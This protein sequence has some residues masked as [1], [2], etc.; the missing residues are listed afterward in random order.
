MTGI[1]GLRSC[2]AVAACAIAT[3]SPGQTAPPA[4]AS[5]TQG[6]APGK[7][8]PST[9]S[10]VPPTQAPAT[11]APVAKPQDWNFHLQT[12]AIEQ[13]DLGFP[14]KYSGPNSLSSRGQGQHTETLDL[15]A[16]K[17][18]WRGAEFHV[19][20][21]I[22]QGFGLSET[23]GIEAFPNGDAYKFG[24][25]TPYFIFARLFIRQTFG[26][27]GP[28][29]DVPDTAL[30][31][32]GKQDIS[33]ITLTA[34]RFTP[35]DVVDTNAYASNPRTQFMNWGFVNNLTWDYPAD[36]VGYT[37]GLT[38]ELNQPKWA[39]RYGCFVMPPVANSF[40]GDD[41]FLM[42]PHEGSF[43]PI[44]KEWAMNL[45][46]ERRYT[47]K[48]HPGSIRP[49]A[50][51]NQAHMATYQDATAILKADGPGADW[52]AARSFRYKYGFGLNWEQ[53]LA[54]NVGAFSRLGWSDGQEEAWAFTDATW[55]ASLG[56]S[57]K[58]DAWKR[59]G[60]IVGLATIVSGAS[61]EEQR[62][63]EAG[64]AGILDGD[65]ALTYAPE[66]VLETYYDTQIAKGLHFGLDY[67]FVANP[68]YNSARGPVSIFGAR[69]HYEF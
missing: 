60:D 68:A 19:D 10:S 11:V 25:A 67:Q 54:N 56:V 58:G 26:L 21:L 31:L 35:T 61:A 47:V 23:F 17:R 22:W 36:S 16:G 13:G 39:L 55:T 15:L 12:T 2:V 48:D 45:E 8:T 6:S 7:N 66:D 46:L 51:L 4:T 20:G 28:Q 50:W 27:G 43:G 30:T 14:S 63:L 33:R 40:T 44:F 64:G 52:E 38:V 3:S 62:F 34:G 41:E 1:L 65:G 49:Q 18:L 59:S 42:W 5:S 69:L 37:P 57:V 32:A 53:E 29:E 9:P 24:T